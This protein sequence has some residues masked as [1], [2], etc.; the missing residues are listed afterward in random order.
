MSRQHKAFPRISF[1]L[2]DL[3]SNN[4]RHDWDEYIQEYELRWTGGNLGLALTHATPVAVSRVTGKGC[5]QGIENV[6]TG[7]VLLS[8]NGM[9]TLDLPSF[10]ASASCEN[11]RSQPHWS[12]QGQTM[13][14]TTF[15]TRPPRSNHP[16]A[17]NVLRFIP[18]T[19]Q[20]LM[21]MSRARKTPKGPSSR[22]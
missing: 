14:P 17:L 11:A 21:S 20:S 3:P 1:D 4:P 22:R 8:I 15:S 10:V 12:S 6:R 7:D 5:P 9:S 18:P 19:I 13:P 16:L 2:V